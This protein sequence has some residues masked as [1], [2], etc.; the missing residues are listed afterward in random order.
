M[1][2]NLD[3]L[4]KQ[5]VK[6]IEREG[7]HDKLVLDSMAIVPRH[8]FVSPEQRGAAYENRPLPIG[9]GQ[10]ISQPSL[11]ARMVEAARVNSSSIVLEIGMGSGYAAA[12]LSRIAKKVYTVE[13]I[14]TFVESAKGR[15]LEL[16]YDNIEAK[17]D[18]GSLGW[19]E[20]APFDA[21]IVSAGAPSIPQC[22][23][24]QLKV[25]GHLVIPVGGRIDQDLVCLHKKE[26]GSC[27]QEM[28]EYVRFVPLIGQE[29]WPK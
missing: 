10:V 8:L 24:D 2:Q 11:V 23:V 16:G 3:V 6:T 19:V 29:G 18:D 22:Y 27:S 13:R 17:C 7:I 21:I 9:S 14:A 4:R 5:M 20:K 1:D 26:D 15:F 12:I 28:I 25:G